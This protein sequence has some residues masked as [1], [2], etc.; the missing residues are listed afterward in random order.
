MSNTADPFASE[1]APADDPLIAV[2]GMAAHLPGAGDIG[3]FWENLRSGVESI[4]R[5]TAEE[6]EAEGVPRALINDPKY[7]RANGV[8]EGMDSFDAGFFGFSPRDAAIM[9][10]QTRHFL[11]CAWHALENSGHIPEVFEG[12][13]GVFAGAGANQYFWKNIV[14][15]P[16]LMSTVGYFLLRH[17]G[18]DKDFL[19]TRASYEL[20]LTGPSIGVQTACSTSLVAIHYACQSLLSWECDM[21]LAGG[22]TIEQ[23]HHVGYLYEEGEILSPDG[24]C[25]SFDA[26]A[27]G[28][29]FGSGAGAVV[30][31]RLSDA[32]A[33]GDTIHAVIRGSAVNNDGAGK[34]SYLAPS[35]DGQAKAVA[36][37]LSIAGVDPSTIGLVEGHGTATP[38]GDPIEVTAL[39]QAFR[40]H[41]EKV[42]YCA[43]GS[44]KSNI[45]HLDTAA[46]VASFIKAVLAL[47]H[48]EIPPTVHFE[49]PNPLLELD[50]SP[51]YVN[52]EARPWPEGSTPRRAVV[53]SLGVGGTNAHVVLEEAPAMAPSGPSRPW[54][55]LTLSGRS[56]T[57]LEDASRELVEFLETH[58]DTALADV[59]YTLRRGRRRFEHR[60]ALVCSSTEEAV[61]T[62][63]LGQGAGLTNVTESRDR[64]DVAFLFAGGGAQYPHMGGELYQNEP[65]FRDIVDAC[66]EYL[67]A[68]E[69]LDLR[70]S[71]F[72]DGGNEDEAALALQR[73]SLALP[74]LFTIQYA[75]ARLWMSWGIEPT[76]MIGHSM[77]EYTAACLA[78]VFSMEEALSLVTLRGRLFETVPPGAMLSVNTDETS[79]RPMIG[80][81]VSIAA[82][83][84]P[85]VVVA[86]GP[87]PAI[88]DLQHRLEESDIDCRRVRIDVAAHS[89][90]LDGI[91][92][93]F[94]EHLESLSLS[95]PTI[96]V[97]SNLT[98]DFAGP[99]VATADYW[100][101]HLR[102]TVQF[103]DG[104]RKLVRPDGPVILEVGP[105][106]TLATLV[107]M[108][109]DWTPDQ[110]SLSSL[111]HP[112]EPSDAQAFQLAALGALWAHG[113]NPDWDGFGGEEDRR[114]IPL[115]GYPF[116]R[117]SY[118]VAPPAPT[119]AR[120]VEPVAAA[121]SDDPADWFQQVSWVPTPLPESPAQGEEQPPALVLSES[122]AFGDLMADRLAE[123]GRTV[124]RVRRGTAFAGSGKETTYHVRP[125]APEDWR[126]LAESLAAEGALPGL[127]VHAW[128][129]G[130]DASAD[131]DSVVDDGFFAPLHLLQALEG[132]APGHAVR[133]AAVTSG[134]VA[135]AGN[136]RLVP[137]RATL[138]GPIRVARR[139]IPSVQTRLVDIG[140]VP[141][142]PDRMSRL[143]D[144]L[145]AEVA[146]PSDDVVVAYRGSDR[147]SERFTSVPLA[148][149]EPGRGLR[150][151]GVYLITGG[152]GGIGLVVARELAESVRAR[153]VLVSRSGLPPRE[154]WSEWLDRHPEADKKARAIREIE[155][156]EA[157]GSEVLVLRGDT[158]DIDQMRQV[159]ATAVDRFGGVH[160][161]VHA[162]GILDDGPL[163]ARDREQSARVLDPKI[164][165]ALALD[166]AL[167]EI[168]LDFLLLFSSVSAV[169]GAPGQID[170]AAANAFLDAFA[171]ARSESTGS[172][173]L[174]LAWGAWKDVGMAAELAGE[175][176]YD[177]SAADVDGEDVREF[178]HP[179][180]DGAVSRG[181]GER[182][183]RVRLTKDR[184]WMIAE[185]RVRDGEWVLPGSGYVE[186]IRAASRE[187]EPDAEFQLADLVFLQ[188]FALD[189]E[190]SRELEVSLTSNGKGWDVAVLGRANASDTWVEHATAR[191][192]THVFETES[193]ETLDNVVGRVGTPADVD[194]PPHPVMD[195]GPRW[196][197]ITTSATVDGEALLVH[198]LAP[199]FVDDIATVP[200]HPAL[201][202]MATA[203]AQHLIPGIDPASD[204]FVPA[205]YGSL[206]MHAPLGTELKSHVRLRH[207]DGDGTLASFDV[208]IYDDSGEVA[209]AVRDFTMI[210]V[211][212]EAFSLRQPGAGGPQWLQDA[213]APR[214]GRDV[215]RRVLSHRTAPHVLVATRS[216]GDLLADLNRAPAQTQRGSPARKGPAR[217]ALPDVAR[218]LESHEAVNEA[219]AIG[220]AGD[221]DVARVVAFVAY[222]S[223][224]HA[225]VSE[226]RRFMRE[227]LEIR[228]VPQNFV[229]MMALPRGPDGE[230][231]VE[232][233]R[234]PFAVTDDFVAPRTASEEA[235]ASIWSEL[236]GLERVGI[237]DNFLDV[238]GHSLVGIR[239]LLRIQQ[240]TGVRLEAN[241][242]TM[243]TLEQL[244]ADIDRLGGGTAPA[245]ASED[246]AT[247]GASAP[248]GTSPS[249]PDK[250]EAS[251][252]GGI[253]SRV[254]KVFSDR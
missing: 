192:G 213:I 129:L 161:V 115:P 168:P 63:A 118:F 57:I 3:Q 32:L 241:A 122:G 90:M 37:A 166:A 110:P 59:S 24:H 106:R 78:G 147:L 112:S 252:R 148:E 232:E 149:G 13:I 204:F 35:V 55:L 146:A 218:T 137:G 242:L 167:E 209:V 58:A 11:E 219:A 177:R 87:V 92:E 22:V 104:V 1:A 74:A 80:T 42:G 48:A 184:H 243:Q 102:E 188:P 43:L 195:F 225:T 114:R 12:N 136:E 178:E 98:G 138:M 228:L 130:D 216:V 29:V 183:F 111:P 234:D 189:N 103:S 49:R 7:V 41:T 68:R 154:E 96:P 200:L 66:L 233:L 97:I 175:T 253:I 229:E 143:L 221:A 46:G 71:L 180:F 151:Q 203:G 198:S 176:R 199:E 9:D 173:V 19:S 215:L 160:G 116:D 201:L 14:P 254:R 144:Q 121:R 70:A 238:G 20:D 139:E 190:E 81:D 77:G 109:P 174:S 99:E 30:L 185:H 191:V 119:E 79:L 5:F 182:A 158:T 208:T 226:L 212:T 236:L 145:M 39:T 15:N 237:H 2:V 247:V 220:D 249:D 44:V 82:I 17:T 153:L 187:V 170:Y 93:P 245:E 131:V 95:P 65:S 51:F 60:R 133:L 163:L 240:A 94:R 197:N 56:S 194:R 165:G 250:E 135:V 47:K 222:E 83:N 235:I 101:R 155:A 100:V 150:E 28:T 159:V 196:S 16:E 25:R 69:G 75:Q 206:R 53:N 128:S 4:R 54:Q 67:Q 181:E 117:E 227:R 105:G 86:A 244:A 33:D 126:A 36:E 40:A 231:A 84:A 76:S 132:V 27:E 127:I 186:L 251:A 224:A 21:A 123:D 45:G 210:R 61:D 171:R 62:L 108:Q 179:L 207:S 157:V 26:R 89:S 211:S 91:L 239:V 141:E 156:L 107:R 172:R 18:N 164:R 142:H 162:A 124:V 125:G 23:P 34:V 205:G 10:P 193:Y 50:T 113:V 246:Q 73:P 202:D 169:L 223:G 38:V 152:L 120:D 248:N 8:L 134:V 31:R 217:A 52:A 88:D 85:D 72:P 230:I 64:R 214:E 6:L 140:S